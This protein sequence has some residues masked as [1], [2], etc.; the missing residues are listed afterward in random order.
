MYDIAPDYVKIP[1]FRFVKPYKHV[2]KTNVKSRWLGMTLIDAME[3]EFRAYTKEYYLNAINEGKITV[4]GV[5]VCP[6]YKLEHGMQIEHA[7]TRVEPPILDLPIDIV[8]QDIDFVVVSK[9]PSMIV[10]TGGGYHYNCLTAILHFEYGFKDLYVLH[11]LDRLTS[12]LLIF[13]KNR[14]LAQQ[15]HDANSKLNVQK[16]YLARVQ[17]NF[18]DQIL[19][20]NKPQYCISMKDAIFSCCNEEDAKK[21]DAKSAT[22]KFLK[23]WYD[24]I[25]DSSLLECQPITGRTHQ[26]RVHLADLGH[27]ILNDIGYGG[28]FIGNEIINRNFKGLKQESIRQQ[29]VIKGEVHEIIGKKVKLNTQEDEITKGQ[30]NQEQKIADQIDQNLD[31]QEKS[32]EQLEEKLDAQLQEKQQEKSNEQQ[33]VQSNEQQQEKSNEQ[34]QV[35]SNEQQQEKQS[36]KSNEQ[37]KE[38]QPQ[39]EQ[40]Q[41]QQQQNL[42][43]IKLH[44]EQF[45]N[46]ELLKD[47]LAGKEEWDYRKHPLEIY[48][49]SWKYLFNGQEFQSKEPYWYFK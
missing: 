9:P 4:N 14:L 13:S 18:S 49:H 19:E 27:P 17:G 25:T 33:Q 7:T 28:K 5:V 47:C 48:L 8:H 23:L 30:N 21:F 42:I 10:H 44:Q 34:Q 12:G 45:G 15:F 26:I 6:E 43:K 24:P 11:R 1:P 37:Q 38:K 2:Y 29:D 39:T 3:K 31:Q 41:V 46:S 35:Q 32:N 16:T 36:Q 22:T 40:Q 20:N